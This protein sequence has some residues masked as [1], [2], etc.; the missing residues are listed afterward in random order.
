MVVITI[1]KHGVDQP[2]DVIVEDPNMLALVQVAEKVA[3]YK[4]AVLITGETG[5][6]KELIARII[7]QRSYRCSK[8]WVDVNCAASARAP[9]GERIVRL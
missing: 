5:T 7:H 8:P 9:G 6:G 4:A 2:C 3:P 1:Q